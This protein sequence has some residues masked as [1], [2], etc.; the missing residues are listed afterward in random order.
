MKQ[1]NIYRYVQ[2]FSLVMMTAG[3]LCALAFELIGSTVDA[4]GILHEPFFLVPAGW[5]LFLGGLV[6]LAGSTA[7]RFV[8]SGHGKSAGVHC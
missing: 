7:V 5:I 4:A 2:I 3:V 8:K 1:K 6:L